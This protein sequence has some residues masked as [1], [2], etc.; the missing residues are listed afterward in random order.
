MGEH[1]CGKKKLASTLAV[2][3]SFFQG[4]VRARACDRIGGYRYGAGH[5]GRLQW[6]RRRAAVC[7]DDTIG[8]TAAE[9]G[10]RLRSRGSGGIEGSEIAG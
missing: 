8:W 7:G 3:L 5:R 2:S 9:G 4:V 6:S 10:G 1:G